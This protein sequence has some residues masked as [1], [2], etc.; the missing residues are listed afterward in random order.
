MHITY[1]YDSN[2]WPI[3]VEKEHIFGNSD[4][5]ESAHQVVITF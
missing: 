4:H 1:Q 3:R 2:I 5:D